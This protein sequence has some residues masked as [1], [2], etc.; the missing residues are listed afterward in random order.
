MHV[1]DPVLFPCPFPIFFFAGVFRPAEFSMSRRPVSIQFPLMNFNT[2]LG[3]RYLLILFLCSWWHISVIHFALV[4]GAKGFIYA[5]A[6]FFPS[7]P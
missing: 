3:M 7:W 5:Y 2:S 1:S 4:N 6:D